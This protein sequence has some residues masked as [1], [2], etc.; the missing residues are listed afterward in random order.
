MSSKTTNAAQI[1]PVFVMSKHLPNDIDIPT[2]CKAG[3]KVAGAAGIEGAYHDG[4]LWR[5]YAKT[6][7]GRVFLLAN[8]L[9]IGN[10]RV[11]TEATNPFIS[12]GSNVERPRTRLTLGPMPFSISDEVLTRSLE[13]ENIHTRSDITSEKARLKDRTWTGWKTGRRFVWIELPVSPLRKTLQVG[14]LKV[15]MYYREMRDQTSK[16]WNCKEFGHRSVDCSLEVRCFVCKKTGHKKG[17]AACNLG[18]NDCEADATNM[19]EQQ[20]DNDLQGSLGAEDEEGDG[21]TLALSYIDIP[22]VARI[23]AGI[24]DPLPQGDRYVITDTELPLPADV[25]LPAESSENEDHLNS[26][27]GASG[28]DMPKENDK[29][30]KRKV[31][32]RTYA[33]V[34]SQGESSSSEDETNTPLQ[35]RRARKHNTHKSVPCLKNKSGVKHVAKDGFQQTAITSFAGMGA[36]RSVPETSPDAEVKGSMSQKQKR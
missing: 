6:I 15:D 10:R 13:K 20:S 24:R 22:Q 7:A 36:K 32:R 3:E 9:T 31:T 14:Q 29:R 19:S 28:K 18:F 12:E 27:Q 17:D 1:D 4:G 26:N 25:S 5:V 23:D 35:T 33:E 8:G 34:A 21:V 16:C 2:I 11:A 30:V